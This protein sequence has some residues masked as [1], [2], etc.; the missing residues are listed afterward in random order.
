MIPITSSKVY[1]YSDLSLTFK[2]HPKYA[3]IRPIKGIDAIKN[4]IKNILLTKKGER[5]FNPRFGSNVSS[6]LFEMIDDHTSGMIRDEIFESLE[7]FEPR[8]KVR[9]V[10]VTPSPETNSYDINV[11][12]LI[13]EERVVA[14]IK[15]TL[16]RL[17]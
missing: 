13:I 2:I 3:D 14:D 5:P 6:F 7:E 9:E 15:I 8:I 4:S 10:V 12:C 16:E 1:D 17:R 11:T